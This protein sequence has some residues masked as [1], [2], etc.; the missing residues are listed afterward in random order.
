M[1]PLSR[2]WG[3]RCLLG[4]HGAGVRL[5]GAVGPVVG[6]IGGV[7]CAPVGPNQA[8]DWG[9]GAGG[10]GSRGARCTEV[11]ACGLGERWLGL[12]KGNLSL[13]LV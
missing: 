11:G 7:R 10:R 12:A 9:W 6:P 5:E 2:D 13:E 1:G 4:A 3:V 8:L